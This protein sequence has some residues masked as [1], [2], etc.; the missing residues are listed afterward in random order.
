MGLCLSRL[1]FFC[2]S[3]STE[4]RTPGPQNTIGYSRTSDVTGLRE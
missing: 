2:F 3:V 4:I 1:L